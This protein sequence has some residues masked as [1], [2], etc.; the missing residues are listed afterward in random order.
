MGS[1][2]SSSSSDSEPDDNDR[3]LFCFK[4]ECDIVLEPV[5]LEVLVLRLE[6]L[7]ALEVSQGEGILLALTF[8]QE[9]GSSSMEGEYK[10]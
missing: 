2:C 1:G 3:T 10:S 6:T 5:R 8:F 4:S 9:K 7:V